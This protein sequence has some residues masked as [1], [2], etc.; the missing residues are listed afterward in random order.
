MLLKVTTHNLWAE[1]KA[2]QSNPAEYFNFKAANDRRQTRQS[3]CET[4]DLDQVK[5][6]NEEIKW[7]DHSDGWMVQLKTKLRWHLRNIP[8][9]FPAQ[10]HSVENNAIKIRAIKFHHRA[11]T[12][13]WS[14]N[15]FDNLRQLQYT[16]KS[17]L[18]T[19]RKEVGKNF[20][21]YPIIDFSSHKLLFRI[22]KENANV[23]GD[24]KL[25][26]AVNSHEPFASKR[27][28]NLIAKYWY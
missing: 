12:T 24:I 18:H 27:A 4:I 11:A 17:T 22:G 14:S 1:S 13:E 26:A 25:V 7:R 3:T 21:R 10:A 8:A 5:R 23:S 20:D 2:N 15:V 16:P 6:A 19:L 28:I 9:E